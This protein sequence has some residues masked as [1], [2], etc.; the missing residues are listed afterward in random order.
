MVRT[1]RTAGVLLVVAGLAT[2]AACSAGSPGAS[3][4]PASPPPTGDDDGGAAEA[5]LPAPEAAGYPAV[6]PSVPVVERVG[7]TVLA[8]PR[9]VPV[10]FPGET[11]AALLTDAIGKYVVSTEW[12]AATTQYGVGATTVASAVQSADALPDGLAT[13]DVGTWIASHLD[14]TDPAWGPT[15]SATLSSSV[16]VLYP[17]AG[18]TVYAPEQ[19]PTDPSAGTLCGNRPWDPPGWHWQTTPAAPAS[20][21][22]FAVVGACSPGGVSLA[23]GMTS[24]TTHELAEASTDPFYVTS[25]AYAGVDEAHAF[26]EELT[27]GGEIAD[28]CE[29]ELVTP[30]DVGYAVQRLWSDEAA[31]A[32][33]DPCV[34]AVAPAYFDVA[35]DAPDA[36]FDP[37][38]SATVNGVAIPARE[39]RTIAV[40]LISDGPTDAWQV[41]AVDPNQAAGGA[42]L[43]KMSFDAD[44]GSNGDV[45]HLTIQPLFDQSGETALYEIDSKLHGVT[46]RWYGEIVVR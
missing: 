7:G 32:G 18:T 21:I 5:S 23:D 8:T 26:W 10:F 43:L 13:T 30:A 35:A 16:Y 33:H 36:F 4:R 11:Q 46:Q 41:T 37:Y 12:R 2:T 44:T 9:I 31:S 28:L 17:P 25:S 40:H 34:P 27:G 24:T 42:E 22:A 15:D 45:V 19:D 38:A 20:P 39:S 3:D 1:P 29:Q 14:G 6:A